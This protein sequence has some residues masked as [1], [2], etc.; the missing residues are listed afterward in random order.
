MSLYVDRVDFHASGYRSR[1]ANN[2]T[3]SYSELIYTPNLVSPELNLTDSQQNCSFLP[4]LPEFMTTSTTPTATPFDI[5]SITESLDPEA[6][7]PS[8]VQSYSGNSLSMESSADMD[9]ISPLTTITSIDFTE[10]PIE[11]T[12]N[13][14]DIA[15]S[16][17]SMTLYSSLTST[18]INPESSAASTPSPISF[19]PLPSN[20]SG[21]GSD[22]SLE[23]FEVSRTL[24]IR[25][26][27]TRS[28]PA[29]ASNSTIISATRH[30]ET[31]NNMDPTSI[32]FTPIYTDSASRRITTAS[33]LGMSPMISLDTM[34]PT[35]ILEDGTEPCV[36]CWAIPV[37]IGGVTF[38]IVVV[39][40]GG[41]VI[42]R[43]YN[44]SRSG[45]YNV[46][47]SG[48]ASYRHTNR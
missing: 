24:A 48:R 4:F 14:D 11:A 28:L 26:T 30:S 37:A 46:A 20:E 15:P 39:V 5:S 19:I 17:S 12:E 21:S 25:I 47:I 41:Y 1:L 6:A 16:T 31:S 13:A 35:L 33:T 43:I 42:Y 44:A 34:T 38:V 32:Q 8:T 7:T 29:M 40:V 9:D 36:L 27:S 23:P 10:T 18:R 45:S 2:P 3:P 22:E